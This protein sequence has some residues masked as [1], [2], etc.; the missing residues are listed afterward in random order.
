MI[1]KNAMFKQLDKQW[2]EYI[3]CCN[4]Y[5]DMSTIADKALYAYICAKDI[6]IAG[7]LYP[8]YKQWKNK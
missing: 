4:K 6:I 3:G 5:G 8:E 7:G 1:S 2:E